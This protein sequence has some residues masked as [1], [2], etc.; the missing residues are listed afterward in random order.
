MTDRLKLAISGAFYFIALAAQV[1]GYNNEIIAWSFLI[2]ASFL[3]VIP[4][5]HYVS[6]IRNWTNEIRSEWGQ[7]STRIEPTGVNNS[8]IHSTARK[9]V[10]FFFAVVLLGLGVLAVFSNSKLEAIFGKSVVTVVGSTGVVFSTGNGWS[11]LSAEQAAALY[12]K[13]ASISPPTF[14]LEIGCSN[15][16]C[17]QLAE[18]FAVVFK[19]LRWSVSRGSGGILAA[20]T[21]GLVVHPEDQDAIEL[22]KAIRDVTKLNVF[23]SGTKRRSTDYGRTFLIIGKPID[24]GD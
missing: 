7:S 22:V 21:S 16:A 10:I 18:S 5:R 6:E 24:V 19:E 13:L 14:G 1:S 15:L 23:T 12:L 11:P 20:G 2:I 4:A 9:E 3:L 8:T 17:G